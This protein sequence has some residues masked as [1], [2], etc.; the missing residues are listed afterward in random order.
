MRPDIKILIVL[1][2]F[3]FSSLIIVEANEIKIEKGEETSDTINLL[4]QFI[5]VPVIDP[6]LKFEEDDKIKVEMELNKDLLEPFSLD[7]P[8]MLKVLNFEEDNFK[9]DIKEETVG[10]MKL[11]PIDP[12]LNPAQD[13]FISRAVARTVFKNEDRYTELTQEHFNGIGYLTCNHYVKDN[14]YV[15]NQIG[16]LVNLRSI[17]FKSNEYRCDLKLPKEIDNLSNL[18]YLVIKGFKCDDK[19]IEEIYKL[20]KLDNLC[21]NLDGEVYFMED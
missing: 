20:P 21:L 6:L 17:T 8:L 1:T 13:N 16:N 18:R 19:D 10:K 15:T 14:L 12:I 7:L 5:Y 4:D 2:I 9:R 11:Q 3:I